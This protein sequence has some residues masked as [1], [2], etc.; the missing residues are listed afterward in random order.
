MMTLFLSED[1][2]A[3]HP[4]R[5][6]SQSTKGSHVRYRDSVLT[7]LLKERSAKRISCGVMPQVLANRTH[8]PF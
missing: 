3:T 7:F 5:L 4:C 8:S 1:L 6:R 2:H